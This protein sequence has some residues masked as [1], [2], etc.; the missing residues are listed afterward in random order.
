L[1][2]DIP[3]DDVPMLVRRVEGVKYLDASNPEWLDMKPI[4]KVMNE[5]LKSAEKR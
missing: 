2:I 3:K 1:R 5:A 4:L